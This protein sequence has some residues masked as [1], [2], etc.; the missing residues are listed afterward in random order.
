MNTSHTLRQIQQQFINSAYNSEDTALYPHISSS[1]VSAKGHTDIY[2]INLIA[3]ITKAMEL[4]FPVT[5]QLV[6][7]DFFR[8]SIKH[9]LSS[10]PLCSTNL[11]DYGSDFPAFLSKFKPAQNLPWL[12]DI[13]QFEWHFHCSAIA[14]YSPP[15]PANALSGMPPE[16]FLTL[17]LNLHPSAQLF[18]SSWPIMSIW[19]SHQPNSDITLS[20]INITTDG[21]T[22]ALLH[23]PNIKVNI[24]HLNSASYAFLNALQA[25]KPLFSAFEIACEKDED[26]DLIENLSTQLQIGIFS[27]AS[28]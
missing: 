21:P 3:G 17:E 23:R 25:N 5:Q 13:S 11:D 1:P 24:H 7:D 19:E 8:A 12:A 14:P 20:D 27:T 9:Y 16:D 4:T 28:K 22:H 18:Y 15:L 10:S 6:G 2:R 26:F